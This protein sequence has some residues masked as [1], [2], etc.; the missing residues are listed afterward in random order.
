MIRSRDADGGFPY[1]LVREGVV[2]TRDPTNPLEAEGVLNPASGRGPDGELY[3]L[4]RIVAAGNVSRVALA[5]VVASDGVPTSVERLGVVLE[6][7]CSWETA[8]HNAGVEDPRVT[9][10]AALG[11]YVMTY[12]AF[13]PLGPRTALATSKDLRHWERLGPVLY[14]W[15]IDP[16]ADLN[17]FHNKDTAFF[18]EPVTGPDGV[19]SLAVLHRPMGL[20]RPFAGDDPTSDTPPGPDEPRQSIWISF[21]PLADVQRDRRALTLWSTLR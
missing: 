20:L 18:P 4:P 16:G 5:R 3:L 8:R 6:P 13:G 15:E 11:L 1:A 21:V 17:L 10:I 2:M 12:V 19:P 9:W 14:R 7:E